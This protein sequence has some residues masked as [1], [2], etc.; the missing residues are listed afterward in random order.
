M[1]TNHQH[2]GCEILP[3]IRIHRVRHHESVARVEL[4]VE[5]L[6][7]AMEPAVRAAIVEGI[8]AA[9]YSFVAIDLEGFR[10][11]SAHEALGGPGLPV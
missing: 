1:D 6:P 11:G 9:G 7:R 10:S 3:S 2:R 4:P 8:R 5:D